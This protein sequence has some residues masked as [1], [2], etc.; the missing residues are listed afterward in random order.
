KHAVRHIDNPATHV[1]LD[2]V[3][4]LLRKCREAGPNY[5][6]LLSKHPSAQRFRSYRAA[7]AMRRLPGYKALR[8]PLAAIAQS[9]A[10]L[11]ARHAALKLYRTTIYAEHLP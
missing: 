2:S 5:A 10:P 4:T 1:G 9:A 8:A 3:A 7:H 6:R 11:H